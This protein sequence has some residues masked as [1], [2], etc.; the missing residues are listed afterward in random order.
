MTGNEELQSLTDSTRAGSTNSNGV[1]SWQW[2][3]SETSQ[4]PGSMREVHRLQLEGARPCNAR[5]V[6]YLG[7]NLQL[8][9]ELSWVARDALAKDSSYSY[10]SMHVICMDLM[11]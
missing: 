5:Y 7:I 11:L 4:L 10:Q 2:Q 9:P 8:E 3:I 6:A 1:A